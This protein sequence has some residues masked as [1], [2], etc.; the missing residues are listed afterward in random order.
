MG[1]V[2]GRAVG[3]DVGFAVGFC[4]GFAVGLVATRA[5]DVVFVAAALGVGIAVTWFCELVAAL[6]PTMT[7][8]SAT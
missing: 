3:L 8:Q 1:A 2:V 5:A 7:Q 4:V 6:T